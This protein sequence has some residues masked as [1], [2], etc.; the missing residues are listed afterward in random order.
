M[1]TT[2]AFLLCFAMIGAAVADEA[3][4]PATY[5]AHGVVKSVA[6]E[7]GEAVIAHEEIA[8][9]MPAMTMSFTVHDAAELNGLQAGDSVDFRLLVTKDNAWID[10]IRKTASGIADFSAPGRE[11][12]RLLKQGDLVPDIEAL[13]ENARKIHLSDFRGKALAL[14]FVYTRCPLPTY[15]PLMN[16]NFQTAQSLLSRIGESQRCQFLS[17]SLDSAHDTPEVLSGCAKEYG[18]EAPGW[19]F[20]TASSAELHRVGDALGL[21]FRETP[22]GI[23]HNLRTVVLD[24]KGRLWRIFSGNDWTPQELISALRTAARRQ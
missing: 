24:P 22:T 11:Q 20:A 16:R 1:K 4:S 6:A 21:E 17:L 5:E 9:Y 3:N 23:E 2:T 10:R 8:G 14:T 12:A 18:A 13:D 15:C 7:K 19:L